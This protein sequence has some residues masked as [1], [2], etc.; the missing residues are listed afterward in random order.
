MPRKTVARNHTFRVPM[1]AGPVPRAGECEVGKFWALLF[2][3]V[4]LLGTG[5]F[6]VALDA[7]N[8]PLLN[9]WFPRDVSAYGPV[10]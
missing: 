3:L 6:L 1:T 9:H 10:T 7:D 4:P 8:R 5:L 2:L